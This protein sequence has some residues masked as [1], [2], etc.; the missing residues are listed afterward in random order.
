[1]AAAFRRA[2]A[3]AGA[4]LSLARQV[5]LFHLH[6]FPIAKSENFENGQNNESFKIENVCEFAFPLKPAFKNN[7]YATLVRVVGG[8]GSLLAPQ[9]LA[10]LVVENLKKTNNINE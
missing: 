1:M 2:G 4:D 9:L 6:L 8:L 5:L 10:N 7:A 3:R